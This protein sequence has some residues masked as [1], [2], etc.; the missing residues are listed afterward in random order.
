MKR[1]LNR[2]D[3]R[4]NII[5]HSMGGLVARYAAMYGDADLPRDAEDLKPTWAG[6]NINKVFMFGTPNEGSA[7]KPLHPCSKAIR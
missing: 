1:K 4:F 6:A 5:A 2:P 7:G 3:L